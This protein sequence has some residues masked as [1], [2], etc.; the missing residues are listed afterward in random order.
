M[1]RAGPGTAGKAALLLV[2]LL[3]LAA[4]GLSGCTDPERVTEALARPPA[5]PPE[6][7]LP[8]PPTPSPAKPWYF[9]NNPEVGGTIWAQRGDTLYSIARKFR[10][11]PRELAEANDLSPPYD[12]K[13]G[14][15]LKVPPQRLHL[16]AAGDTI[17]G[18]SRLYGIGMADLT[19]RNEIEPPYT[20]VVGD[21]LH[22]PA[23]QPQPAGPEP[24]VASASA[25]AEES[26]ATRVAAV[27]LPPDEPQPTPRQPTAAV[28]TPPPLADGRFVWPVSGRIVAYYGPQGD[29][30]HNDGIN[31]VVPTGTPVRAAE[32]GVVAYAGNEL[33]GFGNLV[34]IK[35]AD[36][37]VTAYAH[38]QSLAVVKGDV[39]ARGQLIAHAGASGN[40]GEP[41][42]H[43]EVRKGTSALDPLTVL[44]PQSAAN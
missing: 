20:I 23:E 18:V 31:I 3:G 29:G 7:E 4:V 6:P 19:R 34:L 10:M 39:V 37:W 1:S 44:G 22:L 35:H 36:G 24:T 8:P 30:R 11:T 17:Y 2:G 16:V 5:P 28:P 26:S 15:K 40:V 43:F 42:V 41:Q 27:P 13:K 14:Q 33:R 12:L 25:A 38:N 21:R 9:A 32:N